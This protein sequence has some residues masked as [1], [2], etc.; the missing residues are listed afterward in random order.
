MAINLESA[1]DIN[2]LEFNQSQKV[3]LK[4]YQ[5][6]P[7]HKFYRL[8]LT[9]TGIAPMYIYLGE[10][11][12]NPQYVYT[13]TFRFNDGTQ[14][15]A[16]YSGGLHSSSFSGYFAQYFTSVYAPRFSVFLQSSTSRGFPSSSTSESTASRTMQIILAKNS[17]FIPTW[18]VPPHID[19][20]YAASTGVQT[21]TGSDQKGVQGE[22]LLKFTFSAATPKYGATNQIYRISTDTGINY[23]YTAASI[24]AEPEVYVDLANYPKVLGKV[25]FTFSV[26]DSRGFVRSF[27]RTITIVPYSKIE[28]T[29]NNT[30]RQD[31]TGQTV[32]LDFEGKWHGSPL[33]LTCQGITA[34]EQGSQTPLATLTPTIT[35]SGNSFSYQN[36]W[37]NVTFDRTKAYT[38]T[39]IFTDDVS[40]TELTLPIPV[41]TP[42]IAVRNQKV[43]I[44]NVDPQ[45]ELDVIGTIQQNG[46]PVLAYKGEIGT[47]ESCNL[48]DYLETGYYYYSGNSAAI[49]NFPSGFTK[50]QEAILV[51]VGIRSSRVIQK[52]YDLNSVTNEYYIRGKSNVW[53]NWSN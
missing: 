36:D 53:H 11:T 8:K 6:D 17:N 9:A 47:A 38:I 31:G 52:L 5:S 33:T 21:L 42:V 35:V 14:V 3:T 2:V 13:Q 30:H 25:V 1:S 45:S 46:L 24:Q 10:F 4:F 40:T 48:N 49:S 27:K 18:T 43:G 12:T 7:S 44:N 39:A 19:T 32:I 16:E 29:Q 15:Y 23:A 22:S 34:T 41:G 20:K 50:T 28:L 51:V 37:D 26:E